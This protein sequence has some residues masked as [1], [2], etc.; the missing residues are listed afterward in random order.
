MVQFIQDVRLTH[1]GTEDNR[2]EVKRKM[3]KGKKEYRISNKECRTSKG[4]TLNLLFIPSKGA[5]S[6]IFIISG[7]PLSRE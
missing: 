7:F 5:G 2:K 1:L 3:K 4:R 6:S